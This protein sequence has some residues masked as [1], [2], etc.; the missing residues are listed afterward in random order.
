MKWEH[1]KPLEPMF[2]CNDGRVEQYVLD[3]ANYG[4]WDK[5]MRRAIRL[6]CTRMSK[7]D[8]AAFCIGNAW[9]TYTLRCKGFSEPSEPTLVNASVRAA[10]FGFSS[11]EDVASF[12]IS[13]AWRAYKIRG[14]VACAHYWHNVHLTRFA[15][16]HIQPD[17]YSVKKF[18][19]KYPKKWQ[20]YYDFF[21]KKH[22]TSVAS[23]ETG[24]QIMEWLNEE[25]LPM[26]RL[27]ATAIYEWTG[28][29]VWH[30][31]QEDTYTFPYD[32]SKYEERAQWAAMKGEDSARYYYG[33]Y[34]EPKTRKMSAKR[35]LRRKIYD[36]LS[37]TNE[38]K[39]LTTAMTTFGSQGCNVNNA[40]C[41]WDTFVNVCEVP[42]LSLFDLQINIPEIISASTDS[43]DP[44]N[45]P[46]Q[47]LMKQIWESS[48]S[49]EPAFVDNK[50]VM[51]RDEYPSNIGNVSKDNEGFIVEGP[52]F[53]I[54]NRFV[55]VFY[56]P[57]PVFYDVYYS[58]KAVGNIPMKEFKTWRSEIKRLFEKAP[59]KQKVHC[60]SVEEEPFIPDTSV[61]DLQEKEEAMRIKCEKYEHIE[62]YR[63]AIFLFYR[64]KYLGEYGHGFRELEYALEEYESSEF[65]NSV[66]RKI[67]KNKVEAAAKKKEYEE[68]KKKRRK[69]SDAK[70]RAWKRK[71]SK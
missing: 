26:I 68:A 39:G 2:D 66:R 30:P 7:A 16:G 25:N 44:E 52:V 27:C 35:C 62:V 63:N 32:R 11:K 58:P 38:G 57:A 28:E 4:M 6:G 70:F 50:W 64:C 9:R 17:C 34:V 10:K 41:D 31:E 13:S 56:E 20:G 15:I 61:K 47:T 49:L 29:K 22:V 37:L 60:P 65:R 55:K 12:C 53:M 36:Y 54:A 1:M 5:P 14:L 51:Q 3:V 43:L 21:Q 46:D 18:R 59:R 8:V 42:D 40:H 71:R 45:P 33:E 48:T 19:C 67:E 23:L 24:D 69:I